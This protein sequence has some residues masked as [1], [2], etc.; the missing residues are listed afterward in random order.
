MSMFRIIAM[1]FLY[2]LTV[3]AVGERFLPE[4]LIEKEEENEK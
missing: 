2:L 3:Y 1:W 4:D